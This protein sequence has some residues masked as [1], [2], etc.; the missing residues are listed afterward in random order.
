MYAC[1]TAYVPSSPSLPFRS[2][3][4]LEAKLKLYALILPFYLPASHPSTHL[5]T[6]SV[7]FCEYHV[8]VIS[9]FR[10]TARLLVFLQDYIDSMEGATKSALLCADRILEDTPAL[11]KA[12]RAR[13]AVAASS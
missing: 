9:S 12:A 13:P 8:S 3:K 2:L 11:A 10:F 4:E 5:P 1:V 7:G 6:F